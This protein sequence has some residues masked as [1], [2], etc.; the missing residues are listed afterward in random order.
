MLRIKWSRNC[1]WF[2]EY[3]VVNIQNRNFG[4]GRDRAGSH[5]KYLSRFWCG[6]VQAFYIEPGSRASN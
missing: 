4:L 2:G 3:F 6:P 1:L 5:G